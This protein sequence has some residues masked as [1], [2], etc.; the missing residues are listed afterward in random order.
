MRFLGKKGSPQSVS[1]CSDSSEHIQE[2]MATI[3]AQSSTPNAS[4]KGN[5][6]CSINGRAIITSG[7]CSTPKST[8]VIQNF[9]SFQKSRKPMIGTSSASPAA[10]GPR[11]QWRT[12]SKKPSSNARTRIGPLIDQTFTF[13]HVLFLCCR[14][15]LDTIRLLI[16]D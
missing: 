10:N 7:T 5:F 8:T 16:L 12:W 9:H 6:H 4:I 2:M 14:D 3:N 13:L 15:S 1:W 11:P